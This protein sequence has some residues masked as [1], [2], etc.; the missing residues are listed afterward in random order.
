MPRSDARFVPR[1]CHVTVKSPGGFGGASSFYC[2]LQGKREAAGE[3]FE[4]SLTDPESGSVRSRQLLVVS[5]TAYLRQFS[6]RGVARCSPMFQMGWCT[7]WC[8]SQSTEAVLIIKAA[9]AMLIG[10]AVHAPERMFIRLCY[11]SRS[12]NSAA[13][14]SKAPN[15]Q[16]PR[17]LYRIMATN[18]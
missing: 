8:T 10:E 1:N 3:G 12:G 9:H 17:I 11:I 14:L 16:R 15:C 7:N 4:P 5:K 2:V 6:V 13:R 18:F